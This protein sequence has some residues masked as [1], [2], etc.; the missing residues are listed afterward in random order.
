MSV[1]GLPNSDII[2]LDRAE[3]PVAAVEV[4]AVTGMDIT[5]AKRWRESLMR[6]DVLGDARFLLIVTPD[7]IYVWDR[8]DATRPAD[9]PVASIDARPIFAPIF[10]RTSLVPERISG[11]ALELL[12]SGWLFEITLAGIDPGVVTPTYLPADLVA[13]MR[14]GLPTFAPAH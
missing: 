11:E 2:V 6:H 9:D 10:A 12:V 14:G 1:V 5:L 8:E 3:R 4:V 13:A 7:R